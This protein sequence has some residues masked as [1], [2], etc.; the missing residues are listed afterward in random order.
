MG[1]Q[2]NRM[3]RNNDIGPYTWQ[4]GQP[5]IGD[6]KVYILFKPGQY[7]ERHTSGVYKI[8]FGRRFYIGRSKLL[9]NRWHSHYRGLNM[10]LND[11][12]D[13]DQ[14]NHG[15]YGQ[16]IQYLLENPQIKV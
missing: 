2:N 13:Y 9:F 15:Y 5:C 4:P 11:Y 16:L 10:A 3:D 7:W 12:P 6:R 14:A 8:T 1:E